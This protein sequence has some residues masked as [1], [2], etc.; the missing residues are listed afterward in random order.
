MFSLRPLPKAP[1]CPEDSGIQASSHLSSGSLCTHNPGFSLL[2]AQV[3][4][5]RGS[6]PFS[7]H[8]SSRQEHRR[9]HNLCPPRPSPGSRSPPAVSHL[10]GGQGVLLPLLCPVGPLPLPLSEQDAWVP[11]WCRRSRRGVENWEARCWAPWNSFLPSKPTLE[12][13]EVG[14]AEGGVEGLVPA[15]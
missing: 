8:K 13:P 3:P 11:E 1:L 6:A 10:P 7:N 2:K 5:L 9:G 12:L 4:S 14:R 15:P